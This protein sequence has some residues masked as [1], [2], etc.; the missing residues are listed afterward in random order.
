M[1]HA[2]LLKQNKVYLAKVIEKISGPKVFMKCNILISWIFS[3]GKLPNKGI[4]S[5][6]KIFALHFDMNKTI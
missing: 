2:K 6:E 5:R 4:K 3:M 1:S